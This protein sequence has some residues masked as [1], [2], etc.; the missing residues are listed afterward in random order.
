MRHVAPA[1]RV[2]GEVTV[3]GDKS[4]SHRALILG[5]LAM[6]RSYVGGLSPAADVESTASCLRA[7]GGAVR[8]FGDGR[9]SLDGAGMGRT[10]REPDGLLDCG[11]SGTTMRLLT[12]VLAGHDV[13]VRL[14]GD[15][16]LRRRPMGRVAEPLR[17]MGAVVETG[18]DG[19]P[20]L[21]VRGRSLLRPIEFV[22]PV[23]SAQLKSAVMLA[24]LAAGG[25]TTVVEPS[26]TR[27]HT[28]RMLRMCGVDVSVGAGRI[29]M[30]PAPL[31]P[32]G[33]RVPGD[34]S[35]AAF[36]LALAAA[37][38]GW[39]VTCPNVTLNPGRTGFLD[40]LEAMGAR[41]TVEEGEA[42]GGVE[43]VGTVTVEGGD[44]RATRIDGELIPRCIDELP[45]LAVLA[46]QAHGVTQIRDAAELRVKESDRI[47]LVVEGLRALGA[48]VEELPDGLVITGPTRLQ[49]AA[50][51]SHGD[52]R[53]AMAWGIAGSLAVAGAGVTVIDDADAVTV[54]YPAF[55]DDLAQLTTGTLPLPL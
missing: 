52:H 18:Y 42:A 26:A 2:D 30:T 9:V 53:L 13:N 33:M 34:L 36:F 5:A 40:A 48:D 46:T 11:N 6:G 4:I 16:S 39:R 43:P 50:V 15:P 47:A 35:S 20:P 27:D 28:E 22:S 25:P 38:R 10:L 37:R 45:V 32:F 8:S 19:R 29:T 51:D 44:L 23:A 1:Q 31:Q 3:P 54:S 41:L 49:P 17:R 7:C 14:D 24:G 21:S 55:F 12:G